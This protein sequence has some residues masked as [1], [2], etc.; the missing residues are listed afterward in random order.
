[1]KVV[2]FCGGF[3]TRLRE[4]SDT[5]PKPLVDIGYRPILW[6]LMKY[7]AHYG[8]KEFILCLGY[9]A[10]LIKQYF[11]EYNPHVSGNV[12]IAPGG[13][14]TPEKSDIDDW[15][16]HLVDTGLNTNIGGRLM[17]IR[18]Y[19]GSDEMFL[20][21]Y[22]DGLS[23]VPLNAQIEQFKASGAI[24]GFTAVQ[25]AQQSFHTVYAG[26]DGFVTQI[27]SMAGTDVWINGG[28]MILRREVFDYM[29]P[30]EELVEEP[31]QRLLSEK[32]L[33]TFKYGGFWKAMDT[34]KDKVAF[35]QM[36]ANGDRPWEVWARGE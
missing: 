3:G 16:I 12:T 34:F 2:I 21:N 25:P 23:D 10:D 9:R 18:D 35:D 24:A 6:H 32:K 29:R 19:I 27:R 17:A 15:K 11:L 33:F 28:Y 22:G 5:I 1:M 30:G 20:A 8:H 14:R 4:H 36:D 31:F 7:Y 26:D 13:R